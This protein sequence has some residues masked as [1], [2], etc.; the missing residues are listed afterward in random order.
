MRPEIEIGRICYSVKGRDKGRLFVIMEKDDDEVLI[1]DGDLRKADKPK[2]K[3]IKHIRP[4]VYKFDGDITSANSSQ[5]NGMLR[6]RLKEIKD[7]IE[8]KEKEFVKE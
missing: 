7:C 6:K 4:T 1:A 2:K 5:M 8:N 3:N